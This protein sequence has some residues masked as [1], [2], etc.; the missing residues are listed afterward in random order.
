MVWIY[1][2][3]IHEDT[4]ND[5]VTATFELPGLSK[6][7]VQIDADVINHRLTISGEYNTSKDK[8]DREKEFAVRESGM[9]NSRAACRSLMVL[10]YHFSAATAYRVTNMVCHSMRRSKLLSRTAS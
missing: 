6:E 3:N 5:L 7:S 10:R 2:A 9:A 1:R 4:Q 8:E